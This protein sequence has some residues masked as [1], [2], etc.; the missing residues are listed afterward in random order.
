MAASNGNCFIF[1]K[2]AGKVTNVFCAKCGVTTI[3]SYIIEKLQSDIVL[4][5]NCVK[6]NNKVARV[7]E[8][9]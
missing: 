1:G 6:C 4:Q 5:G 9:D 7:V 2:T 8:F 3:V